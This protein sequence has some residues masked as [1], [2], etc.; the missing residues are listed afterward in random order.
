MKYYNYRRTKK[1][2]V[3]NPADSRHYGNYQRTFIVNDSCNSDR[4]RAAELFIE[5]MIEWSGETVSVE[6]AEAALNPLNIVD[7]GGAWDNIDF[8][9]YLYDSGWFNSS[10]YYRTPNGCLVFDAAIMIEAKCLDDD[11]G[12]D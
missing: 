7:S 5:W 9:R 2:L 1:E 8:I 3:D 4:K 10:N 11:E 6:E 12:W